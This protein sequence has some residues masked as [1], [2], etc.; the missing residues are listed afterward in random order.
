MRRVFMWT[1]AVVVVLYIAW[2]VVPLLLT[3]N[4]ADDYR[5]NF[6]WLVQ[7]HNGVFFQN[8]PLTAY[9]YD[10]QPPLL[11]DFYE[12]LAKAVHPYTLTKV[13]SIVVV[14]LFA[15][16][17]FLI[18][19]RMCPGSA[20]APMLCILALIDVGWS[21]EMMGGFARSFGPP[22]Q[23][24]LVWAVM[25]KKRIA[26]IV[27]LI[28][29]GATHPQSLILGASLVATDGAMDL[30]RGRKLFANRIEISATVIG[31]LVIASVL[32]MTSRHMHEVQETVGPPLSR[33]EIL[34]IPE[35]K[36]SGRWEEERPRL[37]PIEIGVILGRHITTFKGMRPHLPFRTLPRRILWGYISV[38]VL[39]EIFRRL[40]GTRFRDIPR[41]VP[42]LVAIGCVWNIIAYVLLAR[43]Y[44]PNRYITVYMPLVCE[45]L[46]AFF[47]ARWII[48]VR[49]RQSRLS[50][51]VP[52]IAFA[53]ISLTFIE[54]PTSL[55]PGYQ[56]ETESYQGVAKFLRNQPEDILY[57]T[58]PEED[59]DTLL[60]LA[61]RQTYIAREISH[62]LFRDFLHEV[63]RPRT[64]MVMQA[65]FPRDPARDIRL[66]RD[67]GVDLF[68]LSKDDLEISEIGK[69]YTD[70]P[71]LSELKSY[72]SAEKKQERQDFWDAQDHAKVYEDAGFLIYDLRKLDLG[73][74]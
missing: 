54:L 71:Y 8:D 70:E 4:L 68:I 46:L 3:S 14:A 24:G 38:L 43:L 13:I 72:W 39:L 7:K 11:A 37:I 19:E 62:P 31:T 18:G 16:F 65:I 51:G 6:I 27:L 20:A 59:A 53:I 61:P 55:L 26:A 58:D 5:Q 12:L 52:A 36:S 9:S 23:V 32:L 29:A 35:F 15:T 67:E 28:L 1:L 66:L 25:A 48:R 50:V 74:S 34:S 40:S 41:V 49:Q 44:F 22:L 10:F 2:I 64:T 30:Y 73:S 69:Y 17:C 47:F 33:S 45:M 56:V 21:T 42:L 63:I 57:A 60:A